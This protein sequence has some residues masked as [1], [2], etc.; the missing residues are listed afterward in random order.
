MVPWRDIAPTLYIVQ[1]INATEP[2]SELKRA[3]MLIPANDIWIAALAREHGLPDLQIGVPRNIVD[4]D[5]GDPVV[6]EGMARDHKKK[7]NEHQS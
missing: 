5:D 6:I 4:R 2:D 3:G 7:K 1:T